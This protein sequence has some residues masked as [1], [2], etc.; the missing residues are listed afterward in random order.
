MMLNH[1][2]AEVILTHGSVAVILNHGFTV[3][4]ILNPQSWATGEPMICEMFQWGFR[5]NIQFPLLWNIGVSSPRARPKLADHGSSLWK[6][7]AGQRLNSTTINVQSIRWISQC[8]P[9]TACNFPTYRYSSD[10]S[11]VTEPSPLC[12]GESA[13]YLPEYNSGLM[14]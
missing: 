9:S 11:T 7:R 5:C 14:S 3:L 12:W 10:S 4:E 1:R 13:Y 8:H 6:I 2:S